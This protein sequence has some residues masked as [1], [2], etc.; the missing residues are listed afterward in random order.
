MT[1]QSD[2]DTNLAAFCSSLAA[3]I[4]STGNTERGLSLSLSQIR[5]CDPSAA[6]MLEHSGNRFL[7]QPVDRRTF[8]SAG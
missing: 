4:A 8:A 1:V 7:T 2:L 5:L 6:R 3:Y